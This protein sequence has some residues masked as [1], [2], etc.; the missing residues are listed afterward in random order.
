MNIKVDNQK[1]KMKIESVKIKDLK[2]HPS[3][4]REHPDDEIKHLIDSIK[5]NGIYRNIVI[6]KDNTIL[7]GHGVV[8]A[9]KKIGIESID[10]IRLNIESSSPEAIKVLIGDNEIA[11]LGMIN[12]RQLSELLKTIKEQDDLIGTGYDEMMLANLIFIS[13]PTSEIKDFNEAAGVGW[14]ARLRELK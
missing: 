5:E 13:R 12:D 4:Y 14:N 3:N 9:C 6:A 7:A 2:P 10:V 8:M 1:Y 11:H